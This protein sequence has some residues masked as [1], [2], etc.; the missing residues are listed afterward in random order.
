M[1]E[2]SEKAAEIIKDMFRDQEKIPSIRVTI[3][4]G[5]AGPSLGLV[6]DEPGEDDRVFTLEDITY[7]VNKD[8]YERVKPIKIDFIEKL[9]A[10]GFFI[11]SNLEQNPMSSCC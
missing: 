2:V 4:G 8:L 3:E 11:F 1:F 5:W 6:L 10:G 7:A 9:G